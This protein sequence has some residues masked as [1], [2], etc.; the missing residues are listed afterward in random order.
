MSFWTSISAHMDSLANRR[1]GLNSA[2][3]TKR[4]VESTGLRSG[5]IVRPVNAWT[6]MGSSVGCSRRAV[7][8]TSCGVLGIAALGRTQQSKA[9]FRPYE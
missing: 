7:T 4:T 2:T 1:S 5:A 9:V 8:M 3:L 6:S